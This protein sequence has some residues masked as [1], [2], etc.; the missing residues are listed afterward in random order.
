MES[1]FSILVDSIVNDIVSENPLTKLLDLVEYL[2]QLKHTPR[3]AE[4]YL[5][6]KKRKL[7]VFK[8]HT[9]NIII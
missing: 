1:H 7:S 5:E 4:A 3:A 8:K 2:K 6:V 9:H